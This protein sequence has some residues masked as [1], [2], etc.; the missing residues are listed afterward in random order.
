MPPAPIAF[1]DGGAEHERRGGG[2]GEDLEEG[3]GEGSEN[4]MP[5][6]KPAH[7]PWFYSGSPALSS[8]AA[9]ARLDGQTQKQ[10]GGTKAESMMEDEV[11]VY[12]GPGR[13]SDREVGVKAVGGE[14]EVLNRRD[15][16]YA[17]TGG[18]GG[19]GGGRRWTSYGYQEDPYLATGGGGGGGGGGWYDSEESS[20]SRLNSCDSVYSAWDDAQQPGG[21]GGQYYGRGRT[22]AVPASGMAVGP[23]GENRRSRYPPE[24][25]GVIGRS[26]GARPVHRAVPTSA[27]FPA[28][29]LRHER[30]GGYQGPHYPPP[31]AYLPAHTYPD[32]DAAPLKP[33]RWRP[34]YN[35]GGGSRN[36]D[37]GWGGSERRLSDGKNA[38]W[39]PDSYGAADE[40]RAALAASNRG[41]KS[42]GA[43]A[44][45]ANGPT[46]ADREESMAGGGDPQGYSHPSASS[47][48]A[49]CDEFLSEDGA[50]GAG[51]S[52]RA[53]RF[54]FSEPKSGSGVAP[55][56]SSAHGGAREDGVGV[57]SSGRVMAATV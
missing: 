27:M 55:G 36:G 43:G 42:R 24:T 6:K 48:R 14:G 44:G 50:E 4:A 29:F 15:F 38:E 1:D 20:L 56:S 13:A 8:A 39:G 46:V 5:R 18:S 32:P 16:S 21:G 57:R 54:R 26:P 12:T 51:S 45:K 9:T 34:V 25:G 30:F 28:H 49:A 35:G 23:E 11:D 33:S 52:E 37:D 31:P 47:Y 40:E 19:G 17:S 2:G 7:R 41:S 22:R 3:R 10:R 53:T